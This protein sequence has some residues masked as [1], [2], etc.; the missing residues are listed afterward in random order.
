MISTASHKKTL[1][2]SVYFSPYSKLAS[3]DECCFIHIIDFFSTIYIYTLYG[4]QEYYGI[5]HF[6]SIISKFSICT[7]PV[8][9]E[10]LPTL[11]IFVCIACC[12]IYLTLWCFN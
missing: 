3:W 7:L 5:V 10:N 11:Y 6:S 9:I 2:P 1:L 12:F 8:C 4:L